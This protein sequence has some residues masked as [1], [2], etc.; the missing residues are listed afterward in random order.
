MSLRA[1]A[2]LI[3]AAVVASCSPSGQATATAALPT[4]TAT[5]PASP[6]AAVSPA[7]TAPPAPSA[8]AM[9]TAWAPGAGAVPVS[10]GG[11]NFY[12]PPGIAT[13][14]AAETLPAVTSSPGSAW[15]I[16]P[17]HKQVSLSGY[18]SPKG[19]YLAPEIRLYPAQQYAAANGAAAASIARLRAILADPSAPVTNTSAPW[20]P[21]TP[22][23]QSMVAQAA[24][25]GF[26]GGAGVRFV[27]QYDIFLDPVVTAPGDPISNKLLFYCFEGLT[28]DGKTYI[29]AVLPLRSDILPDSP[30]PAAAVPAGGVA[31]P[32][33]GVDISRAVYLGAVAEA[34]DAADPGSFHPMVASLDA[35]VESFSMSG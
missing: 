12:V 25:V 13:A 23:E 2:L 22:G 6:T 14:V 3:V 20:L 21:Y 1:A 4:A 5:P 35:L 31:Y 11:L 9:A 15:L 34:L 28:A 29:V 16:A 24:A 27:T 10:A 33:L 7:A 32:P 30:D 17:A 19:T 18:P 8:P 26:R